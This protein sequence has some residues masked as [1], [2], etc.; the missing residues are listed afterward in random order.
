MDE[1]RDTEAGFTLQ[2]QRPSSDMLPLSSLF[3]FTYI[4]FLKRDLYVI[5]ASTPA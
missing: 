3:Y 1:W 2:L 5:S 4:S